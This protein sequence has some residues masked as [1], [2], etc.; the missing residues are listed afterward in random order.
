MPRT[1]LFIKSACF[2]VFLASCAPSLNPMRE[3]NRSTPKSFGG[4]QHANSDA[5]E[6]WRE[7]FTDTNLDALVDAAL[8]NNQE[9]NIQLQETFIANNEVLANRGAYAPRIDFRSGVGLDKS[10]RYTSQGI[11]DE[12]NGLPEHVQDY[13]FGFFA[14]WEM[15]VWKKM[16]NATKAATLRY[17]SS[18]EGRKFIVTRLVA[19][20]ANSYYELMALDNQ[21]EVLDRNIVIQEEALRVVKLQKEA[22]RVTELAVQRFEA[23]VLKN[24]SRI[25][26]I[27]QK[28]VETEN[29]LNFLAGRFPQSVARSSESF[30]ELLPRTIQAGLPSQ[31]LQNRPDVTRAELALAVAKLDVQVAK[32]YFYP[33]FGMRAGIG[34]QAFR[35]RKL[36]DTPDSLL[37]NISA[38]LVAPLI[39]RNEI[40][41][42]YFSANS[43]QIQAVFEYE[44]TVL[45]AYTE[46]AN[47][48]TMIDNLEKSFA[49]QR[50]Q[51]EKLTTSIAI[52]TSLFTSA[53]ADYMEVLLTRRDALESQMEL[54]ENKKRQLSAVVNLYQA[55]GGGWRQ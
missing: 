49:L 39:N 8:K 46:V 51:V 41:A 26:V 53:R 35:I 52:S 43:K 20:I 45:N 47:Q 54:I 6:K 9:L 2:L 15:D 21:L 11:A 4:T 5:T 29:K 24:R 31:L 23:E 13:M 40:K 48:L 7:F 55:L 32:A 19:E 33:S 36:I 30:N 44:Q 14:S 28:I 34:Y 37:Y 22:A 42:V 3:V 10:S 25:Y 50:Q 1:H 18:L 27:K 12:R 17:L 38:D 16:R